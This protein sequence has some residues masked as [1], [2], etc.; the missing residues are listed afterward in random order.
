MS[1]VLEAMG[2]L[3]ACLV[4]GAY[5]LLSLRKI[6]SNSYSYQGMNIAGAFLLALYTLEKNAIPSFLLNI[7]WCFIGLFAVVSLRRGRPHTKE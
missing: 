7:V 3:G 5:A 6:P 2:W 1:M 4:L